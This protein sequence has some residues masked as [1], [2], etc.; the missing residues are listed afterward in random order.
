MN[1]INS[2]T[3]KTVSTMNRLAFLLAASLFSAAPLADAAEPAARKPNVLFIFADDLGWQDVGYNDRTG[4]IETPNID[5]L[6]REG[7]VFNN[8]YASMG[9][10]APSR[11]CLLSG[12]YTPRHDVYAVGNTKRGQKNL[13]RLEPI[14]NKGGL[15]GEHLT[16]ADE[17]KAAGY[18]TGIFGKWH[19]AA[20][21]VELGFDVA[22]KP[23][24][25]GWHPKLPHFNGKEDPKGIYSM[26]E[27]A[28]EFMEKNKDRPFLLYLPHNAIHVALAARKATLERFQAKKPDPRQRSPTYGACTYDLDDGVGLMLKKLKELG[29]EDNTLVVF[30][31][32]NGAT[33]ECS[34]E[35]LR[36]SK[37]GYY[38]GGIRV[39]MVVRWP[40]VVK[41]GTTSDVPVINVDLFPTFLAAAGAKTDKTLDGES[42][43]PLFKQEGPL[44]RE[45]IF[46]H[47][48]GYID[49]PVNRGRELDVRTGFR[50][51]PV[52]VIRKGDWKLHLFHEE[53]HLDGGREKLATNNAVELYNLAED[54][55][56]RRNL[57]NTNTAK[58]DELLGEVL[59]WFKSSDAKRPT[60][61]NPAYD[62]KAKFIPPS[63]QAKARPGAKPNAKQGSSRGARR[64]AAFKAFDTD[65]NGQVSPEEFKAGQMGQELG[66][67]AGGAFK[68]ID[69][70]SS[71]GFSLPEYKR[72]VPASAGK[73]AR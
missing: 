22:P 64:E 11:A 68:I 27:A 5:N 57:A 10:C 19:F 40:G 53:W 66:D 7:M 17:L 63:E 70:D 52:S 49:D 69:T 61:P 47:F 35:P 41:P 16:F 60:Q 62:P 55:G 56:E 13:M 1:K 24:L 28:F 51:R 32:D 14:P 9:N 21:P 2:N 33:Q 12:N 20:N 71:G 50:S 31:S 37:G 59:A 38:E 46:W 44:K 36:G 42:L 65:A 39:P 8:S 6:A 29:L 58:R 48:P 3:S 73:G 45:A 54:I 43:L 67:R 72:Y 30:T 34:Q 18:A 25:P 4:F 23:P 15:T 26:T